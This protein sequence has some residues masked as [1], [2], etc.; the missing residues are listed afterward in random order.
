LITG[1]RLRYLARQKN[2]TAGLMEKDYV[3]SWILYAIFTENDLKRSVVFKGGTLLHKI[4]FKEKWRFSEDIDLTALKDFSEA[5][6]EDK[7]QK[8]LSTTSERSGIGFDITSYHSN[9]G[10]IQVKIQYDALL[11]QKNTTKIDVTRNEKVLFDTQIKDHKL[12]DIPTFQLN[13]YSLDEIFVE[14]IRS[15][16]ERNR[17]RDY[18]DV[19]RMYC[20]H[21]FKLDSVTD[22]LKEKMK[23]KDMKLR[24]EIP[25]EKKEELKEYWHTNLSRFV[26]PENFPKFEDAMKNIDQLIEELKKIDVDFI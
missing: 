5:H 12:E 19:Y 4:Y 17:A 22:A 26:S 18:Y 21:D 16:F 25:K 15:L 23:A 8:S 20:E 1:P 9:P 2:L 10:Y 11:G 3:N 24:M 14:K 13:C 7:L 6:F